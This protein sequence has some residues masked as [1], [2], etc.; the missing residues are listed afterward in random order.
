MTKDIE[1]DSS[2]PFW[3]NADQWIG[4]TASRYGAKRERREEQ[5]KN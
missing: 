2:M 3:V 4:S 5:L 1:G